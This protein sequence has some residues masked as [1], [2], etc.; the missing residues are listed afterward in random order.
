MTFE[1]K[2]N[3]KILSL[4][5]KSIKITL[6]SEGWNV[7]ISDTIFCARKFS[8]DHTQGISNWNNFSI[9]LFCFEN[10][11]VQ[12]LL[13]HNLSQHLLLKSRKHQLE[14]N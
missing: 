1:S 10:K 6:Y 13:L 3:I 5:S 8:L 4:F 7:Q 14:A 2:L 11:I 9:I 12:L